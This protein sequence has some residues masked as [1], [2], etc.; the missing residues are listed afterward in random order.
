LIPA[1]CTVALL[2]YGMHRNPRL[3]PDP[4]LFN[5]ERFSPE[6]SSGRHPFAFI[7]FSAGPRNCI[8]QRF[9]FMEE[10]VL[11]ASLL[12]RFK[13]SVDYQQPSPVPS[14]QMVLKAIGGIH[15]SV[16]LR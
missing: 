7:P 4:L 9:A 8:G 10:K 13:F 5:P 2:I 1:G 12:R 16:S 14:Y 15:L 3:F 6:I 11:M